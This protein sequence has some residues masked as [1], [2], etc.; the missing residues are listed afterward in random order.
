MPQEILDERRTK[1]NERIERRRGI[2]GQDEPTWISENAEGLVGLVSIGSTRDNDTDM[3]RR[4][5]IT[6][7]HSRRLA[8]LLAAAQPAIV[9][10]PLRS[11]LQT[12]APYSLT[13]CPTNP[14]NAFETRPATVERAKLR[15]TDPCA[16]TIHQTVTIAVSD[17]HH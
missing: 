5:T 11:L 12:P 14:L 6:P 15:R 3:P 16:T 9:W 13:E 7:C 10:N 2:L 8:P 1:V 17:K 4:S